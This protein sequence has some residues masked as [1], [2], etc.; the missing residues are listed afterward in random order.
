MDKMILEFK[1]RCNGH[2]IVKTSAA[3]LLLFSALRTQHSVCEGVGS[4]PGFARWVKETGIA[5]NCSVGHRCGSELVLVLLWLRRWPAAA[6]PIRPL[7][8]EPPHAVGVAL[9]I[10]ITKNSQNIFENERQMWS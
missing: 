7:A 2:R 3:F 4:I 5:T 1:C 10:L 6:A 8:W 9:I